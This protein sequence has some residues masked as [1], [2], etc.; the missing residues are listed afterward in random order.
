MAQNKLLVLN[1]ADTVAVAL[2]PLAA[3]ETLMV[4]GSPLCTTVTA[5]MDIAAGHKIALRAMTRGETVVKY[6]QPIGTVTRDIGAG[7]HVHIHNVVSAR[8]G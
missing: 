6:G 2:A 3:G 7:E 5:R 1:P 8:A 4:S